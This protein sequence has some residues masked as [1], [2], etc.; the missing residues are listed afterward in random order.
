[1]VN[2]G[3]S[4]HEKGAGDSFLSRLSGPAQRA[5]TNHGITTP[6]DLSKFSK[7]EILKLHGMGPGSIP[8]LEAAL[9]E[10][11]LSFRQNEV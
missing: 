9:M 6:V 2:A 4:K 10:N 5:L 11:G 1:M 7:A 8:K 3:K